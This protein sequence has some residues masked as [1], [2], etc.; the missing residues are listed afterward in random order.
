MENSRTSG[1]GAGGAV[2]GSFPQPR[3]LLERKVVFMVIFE[4]V[5]NRSFD[6]SHETIEQAFYYASGFELREDAVSPLI[7]GLTVLRPLGIA[8]WSVQPFPPPL[9]APCFIRGQVKP[10]GSL[11]SGTAH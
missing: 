10:P 8:P 7:H 2:F 9:T 3:P 11:F 6:V 1:A 4:T 5:C